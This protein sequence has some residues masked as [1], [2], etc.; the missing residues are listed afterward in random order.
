[1]FRFD[2]T[3]PTPLAEKLL[4]TILQHPLWTLGKVFCIRGSDLG[5]D[6]TFKVIP[7]K[8]YKQARPDFKQIDVWKS[9]L[10]SEAARQCGI[11]GAIPRTQHQFYVCMN[12]HNV[13]LLPQRDSLTS[14]SYMLFQE[15]NRV[16]YRGTAGAMISLWEDTP[17]GT[18]NTRDTKWTP[19]PL[20]ELYTKMPLPHHPQ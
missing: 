11:L 19:S 8:A 1:M 16:T 20:P 10:T 17:L 13:S 2:Y 7:S 5:K 9:L 18:P 3:I 15:N 6:K 14:M 12:Y 4:S